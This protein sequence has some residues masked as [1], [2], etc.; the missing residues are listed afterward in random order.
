MTDFLGARSW[1]DRG[2]SESFDLCNNRDKVRLGAQALFV[3]DPGKVQAELRAIV[4]DSVHRAITC[5]GLVAALCRRGYRLRH[6]SSPERAGVV[7]REAT[8]RYL[9]GVRRRLI[10]QTLVP[11]K[12]AETLLSRLGETATD[13]VVTGKAGSGKTACVVE[14]TKA[15]RERGLPVLTFRLDRI[16]LSSASTTAD[17]GSHLDLEE[18][19][20]LVLAAAAEAAGRPSVLIV[21]QLDAVSIMSGRSSDAL[22]IVER[23]LQE[24]RGARVRAV[25]HTVVVCRAFD[26]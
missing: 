5:Q 22:D 6:L 26:W 24:A 4:E 9:D 25:L 21:D 12:A 15:L 13:S 20:A 1:F 8:N 17:L 18:S 16:R 23:L 14:V 10:R 19:P 11:R 3:G 2:N 7:V